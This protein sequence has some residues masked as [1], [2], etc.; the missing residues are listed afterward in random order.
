MAT[1]FEGGE[2]AFATNI[3]TGLMARW[4]RKALV[5]DNKI[6]KGVKSPSRKVNTPQVLYSILYLKHKFTFE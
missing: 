1:T 5:D 3:S 2:S 4:E 6:N